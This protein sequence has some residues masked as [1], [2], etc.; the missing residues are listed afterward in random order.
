M[1]KK[2]NQ[3]IHSDV[4]GA[5]PQHKQ[6]SAFPERVFLKTNR[7]LV[8]FT[9]INLAITIALSCFFVY[10]S[11]RANVIVKSPKINFIYAIDPLEKILKPVEGY[12]TTAKAKDFAMEDYLRRYITEWHSIP[13]ETDK[14]AQKLN[15]STA[16]VAQMSL[17]EI[18]TIYQKAQTEASAETGSKK[19]I[20][21]VH[22]YDFHNVSGN[23][24]SGYI[25]TFDLPISDTDISTFC[26]CQ[27]NSKQCLTC[28]IKNNNKRERFKI[29]IRAQFT[30]Y[31]SKANP[32]GIIVTAYHIG[33][34]P[35][36]S[37]PK[38]PLKEKEKFWDLPSPLRPEV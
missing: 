22:I 37:D 38:D 4:L 19:S 35:I 8:V 24:W 17:P 6:V 28:K 10:M 2:T 31:T 11:Q 21:D 14:I 32:L 27:D 7:F 12:H 13:Y 3:T 20:R 25:E 16:F 5:Y 26:Q 18:T 23:L 29:W 34:I 1:T 36:H 30:R 9:A 33:S 15:K